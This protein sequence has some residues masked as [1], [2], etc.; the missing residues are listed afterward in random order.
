MLTPDY[1]L[2]CTDSLVELMDAY[3]N[4]VVADIARRIVKTG[5]ITETAFDVISVKGTVMKLT[6]FGAGNDR[7]GR[8]IRG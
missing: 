5:T 1:L 8:L 4:A 7:I 6:R 3:D 2:H